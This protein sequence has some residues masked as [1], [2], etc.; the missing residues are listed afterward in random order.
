MQI[1]HATQY[2]IYIGNNCLYELQKFTG[3]YSRVFVLVDENTNKHCLKAISNFKFPFS[4]IQIKS[5]EK[6]K[7]LR[8]CEK[9][10]DELSKQNADRKSLL[11]NLGGGVICDIG[12]FC[13]STYKRGIDFINIPTTL[14]AQVDASVG[15]KTGIDFLGYKNHI[16]TFSFPK[17]V[18]I[19]PRFLSTLP[20]RQIN[21]GFAEIIKHALIADKKYW[22]QIFGSQGRFR[23]LPNKKPFVQ[24]DHKNII[25][26]IA[27]SIRIKNDIV[28]KDPYERGLRKALNFG[29]TIGHAVE[30]ASL[31][32]SRPMLHGE[33]IAIGMICETYLS[34][35]KLK[36]SRDELIQILLVLKLIFR[37]SPLKFTSQKL[38]GLMKQ[39]KKNM[40]L[41]SKK[42]EINFTL[43]SSIGKARVNNSCPEKQ[44]AES[45]K[46]FNALCE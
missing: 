23:K 10:W 24:I 31:E 14:L 34:R 4:V 39:D 12:G 19:D 27:R 26:L 32:T 6:N 46:F 33:A 37:P 28:K 41:H 18:F 30:T 29:H 13:A 21:S 20:V 42:S 44:I 36:L 38:L 9:I 16:G 7:N 11:V 43:L 45:I 22:Q 25:N 35:E 2:N 15:G 5:G 8:T 17:A 3:N 1:V 40:A